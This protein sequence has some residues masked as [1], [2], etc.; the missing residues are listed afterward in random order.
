MSTSLLRAIVCLF[1]PWRTIRRLELSNERLCNLIENPELR[2]TIRRL[3]LSNERLCNLIENPELTGIA[4]G[5]EN[6][7]LTAGMRGSGPQ[8][9]AGMFLGLMEENRDKAP[10]FLE[11]RFETS[12]GPILCSVTQP[13]GATPADLLGQAK[14]KIRQ[15]EAQLEALNASKEVT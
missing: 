10:N 15:L 2:R 1:A 5:R 6:A 4:F 3:E 7:D 9:L 11:M 8:L 14:Q 13:H 12:K